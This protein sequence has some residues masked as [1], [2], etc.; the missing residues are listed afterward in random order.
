M[1]CWFLPYNNMDQPYVYIYLLS[2]EP[3]SHTTHCYLKCYLCL[4]Y[5]SI[6][7]LIIEYASPFFKSLF[8]KKY[9]YIYI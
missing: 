4:I 7:P 2:L 5:I 9:I 6:S 1:L 3:P 8:K